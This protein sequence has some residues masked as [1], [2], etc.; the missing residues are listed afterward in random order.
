VTAVPA[1]AAPVHVSAALGVVALPSAPRLAAAAVA[2]L[3]AVFLLRAA[4]RHARNERDDG[5]ATDPSRRWLRLGRSQLHARLEELQA[6]LEHHHQLL[7]Q[8]HHQHQETRAGVAQLGTRLDELTL[9]LSQ[10]R[11]AQQ[12]AFQQRHVTLQRELTA[13]EH[14]LDGGVT[15]GIS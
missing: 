8:L 6:Q 3:L 2:A 4:R 13:L 15:N 10:Q 7:A 12:Q 9:Q 11:H 5:S 1:L 14:I